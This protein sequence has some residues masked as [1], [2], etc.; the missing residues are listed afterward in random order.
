MCPQQCVL[1]Y[2]GLN[3]NSF[4]TVVYIRN[5]QDSGIVVRF[6]SFFNDVFF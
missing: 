4:D 2:Q 5:Y 3:Y 1:V 6:E